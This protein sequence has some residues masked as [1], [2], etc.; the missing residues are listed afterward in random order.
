[1]ADSTP[2]LM[3]GAAVRAARQARGWSQERLASH[4][5]DAL[6]WGVGGQSGVARMESGERPTRL[7]EAVEIARWLGFSLPTPEDDL[8]DLEVRLTEE[9][10]RLVEADAERLRNRLADLEAGAR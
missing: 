5:Q 4:L 8:V 9:R 1:M 6:G 10:L 3:F 2:E 7:N